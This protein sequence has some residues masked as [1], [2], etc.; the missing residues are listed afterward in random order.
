[1]S[2]SYSTGFTFDSTTGRYWRTPETLEESFRRY[3]ALFQSN[4]E[5]LTIERCVNGK[6]VRE[7]L[8]FKDAIAKY[9]DRLLIETKMLSTNAGEYLGNL[10]IIK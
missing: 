1:M 2:E 5:T 9:G 6:E 7:T 10:Y 3:T 8:P 4:P